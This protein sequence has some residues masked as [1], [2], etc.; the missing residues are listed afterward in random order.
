M[1]QQDILELK[2]SYKKGSKMIS[3]NDDNIIITNIVKIPIS[4]KFFCKCTK[5]PSPKLLV[6]SNPNNRNGY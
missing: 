4:M 3:I 5:I 2:Y 1:T 6:T